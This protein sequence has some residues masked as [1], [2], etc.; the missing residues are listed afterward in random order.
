MFNLYGISIHTKQLL[1]I[2]NPAIGLIELNIF[3]IHCFNK[4][5]VKH[6]TNQESGELSRYS[7]GLQAER[8][9]FDSRH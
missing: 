9:G 2:N 1:Y 5:D 6:Y 4:F 8:S 3:Y 7:D